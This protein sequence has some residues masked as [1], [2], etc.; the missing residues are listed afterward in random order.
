MPRPSPAEPFADVEALL[1]QGVE[2]YGAGRL[3]EAAAA[4]HEALWLDPS[5]E[6]ARDYLKAI[7]DLTGAKLRIASVGPGRD[8]T[9]VL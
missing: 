6:K 5:N 2:N 8:Q 3:R 7:A 9:I 1:R 4:F